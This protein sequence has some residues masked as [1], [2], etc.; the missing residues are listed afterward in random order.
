MSWRPDKKW[1]VLLSCCARAVSAQLCAAADLGDSTLCCALQARLL[2]KMS[3]TSRRDTLPTIQ[4]HFRI[5]LDA[6]SIH[7]HWPEKRDHAPD[8]TNEDISPNSIT[9]SRAGRWAKHAIGPGGEG[10]KLGSQ[11]QCISY[12]TNLHDPIFPPSRPPLNL[13]TFCLRCPREIELETT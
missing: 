10:R 1:L 9:T 2:A 12:R 8:Y 13:P 6:L 4:H 5:P 11:C 7:F 3:K